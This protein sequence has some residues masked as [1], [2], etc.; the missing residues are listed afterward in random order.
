MA[1]T[2]SDS[3]SS[4]PSETSTQALQ[5][6]DANI[7]T[8]HLLKHPFYQAWSAGTLPRQA[9]LD[10]VGQ[11][12]AFESNLPRFLTALHARCDDASMRAALLANAWDEEHGPNNHPE[13]W[14]RFGEALGLERSAIV[15]AT[16]RDTTRALVDTYREAAQLA[17][18]E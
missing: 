4:P 16:L 15:G 5:S 8:Q 10:Y 1:R 14:L 18:V 2:G 12:Y 3:P 7:E 6:I 13:L 9:L 11:Y 17:P